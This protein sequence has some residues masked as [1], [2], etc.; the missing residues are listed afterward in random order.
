MAAANISHTAAGLQPV[1]D[2]SER[3][4]PRAQEVRTVS[5]F[6]EAPAPL[7]HVVAVLVPADAV[8]D[9]ERV[10]NATDVGGRAQRDLEAPDD[11]RGA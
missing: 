2:A 3:W 6:E 5:G 9:E 4:D 1:R 11:E 10:L 7:E 8:A